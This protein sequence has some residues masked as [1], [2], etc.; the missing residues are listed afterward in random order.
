MSSRQ[1]FH[2][3]QIAVRRLSAM[4]LFTV[5]RRDTSIFDPYIQLYIPL[6]NPR[7]GPQ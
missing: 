7:T 2:I 3:E 5:P 1:S 6:G 4:K